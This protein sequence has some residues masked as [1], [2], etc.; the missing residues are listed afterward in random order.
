MAL[1]E[2]YMTPLHIM[3]NKWIDKSSKWPNSNTTFRILLKIEL[4]FHSSEQLF[5]VSK[6]FTV[7]FSSYHLET[8]VGWT[9]LHNSGRSYECI[10]FSHLQHH[11]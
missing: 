3:G 10:E 1:M 8:G 5:K 11:H 7:L 2:H 4:Y 6:E 9:D